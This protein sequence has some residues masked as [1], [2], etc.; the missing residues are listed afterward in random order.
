MRNF[1]LLGTQNVTP[2]LHQLV[3]HPEL[4]NQNTI[5]TSHDQSPHTQV[6][7]ILLRF[8]RKDFGVEM[9]IDD[10]ECVWHA[11]WDVLTEAHKLIFDLAYMVKAERI[12]RILLS[13]MAPGK[14]IAPHEDGGAVANYYTRYQMPLQSEPGVM[15][16]CAGECVQMQGG[17]VW[18]F[19]NKLTH[20]V[21]NNSSTDRLAMVVDLRTR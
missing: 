10:P 17:Q 14:V 8:Q 12:G 6:D 4:W 21:V 11:A 9:I 20:S 18:W 1:Q 15:F 5:R 16:D 2:L 3:R 19:N 7:D 13:R